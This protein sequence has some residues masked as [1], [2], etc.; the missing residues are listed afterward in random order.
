MSKVT[1]PLPTTPPSTPHV[2]SLII[3]LGGITAGDYLAWVRDPEPSALD[4][5]STPAAAASG[6]TSASGRPR[7]GAAVR[8]P[9]PPRA[10]A[11]PPRPQISPGVRSLPQLKRCP[12]SGGTRCGPRGGRSSAAR[13]AHGADRDV[14]D[15][16]SCAVGRRQPRAHPRLRAGLQCIP[17][18]AKRGR[19]GEV[20]VGEA[21]DSHVLEHCG[22][23]DVDAFGDL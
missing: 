10:T 4:Y 3:R 5:G 12:L 18:G 6:W 7:L 8:E 17:G 2:Q 22:R 14:G 9:A 15:S 23:G 20:E 19:V 13:R 21:V 1:P 16:E 11:Q